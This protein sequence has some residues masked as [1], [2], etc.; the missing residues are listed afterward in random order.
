[1]P[2]LRQ[3]ALAIVLTTALA[4]CASPPTIVA[5][6][7]TSAPVVPP[8]LTPEAASS[9]TPDSLA[10]RLWVAPAFAPDPQSE[11]GALLLQRVEAFEADH[12]NI[13]VEIRLKDE[14]G[15]SGLL[16]TLRAGS[17]VAPAAV[18]D[19]ITLEASDLA[20]AARAGLLATLPPLAA[21]D[22]LTVNEFA[23]Q[24]A[25]IDGRRYGS[26]FGS[27]ADVMVYRA[28]DL[29]PA[30]RS[31]S[32]LLSSTP[33]FVF[34]A[35]D[36]EALTTLAQYLA[37]GASLTNAS[38]A[39][40]LDPVTLEEVLAF[41][42]SAHNAG[43]LPLTV[44]QYETSLET[45]GAFHEGRATT[46]VSP[47]HVF[48]AEGRPN[49]SAAPLPTRDGVGTC[50]ASTWS[51]AL[52]TD[53]PRRQTAALELLSWLSDPAFLGGWTQALGL[54][55]ADGPTLDAWEDGAEKSLAMQLTSVTRAS[56]PMEVR[57]ALGAAIR[58][59]ID[60]VLSGQ[61]TPSAAAQAA[62]QALPQP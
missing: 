6:T 24:A 25:V 61:L 50:L 17:A 40:Q 47:L 2:R 37:Q 30:P 32:D 10:V 19:L 51:W 46:A 12:P 4:A 13:H 26:P 21:E 29:G 60:A 14:R 49:E 11:A 22:E 54:L 53:D 62:V 35:G 48:L 44:R 8:T 1:M 43:L 33:P 15:P 28:E 42:G 7:P 39:L 27:R 52:V 31:W 41:Y 16:E 23:R 45:W 36:P 57:V 20:E 59:S 34:P 58:N 18:P 5:P 9:P 38:G 56:P 3:R 55:P